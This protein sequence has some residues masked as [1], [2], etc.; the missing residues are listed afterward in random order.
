MQ[1]THIA[2][3]AI[4]ISIIIVMLY[5]FKKNQNSFKS[6][7]DIQT[8]ILVLATDTKIIYINKAGL[9]FFGFK[10][11]KEFISQYNN[12]PNLFI[13][14]DACFSKY[15]VGKKWLTNLYN[16]KDKQIKVK[17][18]TPLDNNLEYYFYIQ[19]SKLKRN[20]YLLSFTNI[21]RLESD[22]DIIRKL[23][24]Y[25]ALT[26]I[27]SRVKFNEM[28][29]VYMERYDRF[30]ETFSIILFDIDHFK[31]I[32]D[33][34]GH[35]IGDRVLIEL[36]STV[37]Q[38]LKELKIRNTTLFSRWGGEEFVILVQFRKKEEAGKMANIIR[39]DISEYP[40]IK[41]IRVTCSFG[42]TE[43]KSKDT[44]VDIFH[45]V[46]EALYEAKEKGRN[47]VVIK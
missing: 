13:E 46:D 29:P 18:K 14:D 1:E 21:T 47:Q 45:R 39:K 43:V 44:Q 42:V 28:F 33:T 3:V 40:F 32:N 26:N 17:L 34:Q 20:H 7:L 36:T 22:K 11:T 38:K 9:E 27:Y 23:A 35:N 8:N 6:F 30:N 37:K 19:I 10:N 4:L 5:L 24:D 2:I 15:S 12:I 16:K 41:A 31:L 25:D